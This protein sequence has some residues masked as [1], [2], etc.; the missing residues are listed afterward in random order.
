MKRPTFLE[1]VGFALAASIG[2]SVAHT[3][4]SAA[5]GGGRSLP[6]RRSRTCSICWC[7]RQDG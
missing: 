3:A 1:G 4:L 6:V 5:V 7:V 2:G